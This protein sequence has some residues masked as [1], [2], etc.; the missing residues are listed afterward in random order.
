MV[1]W[2]ERLRKDLM[3]SLCRGIESHCG[4][5]M[6]VLR[7]KPYKPRFWVAAGVAHKR[8]LTAKNHSTKHSSKCAA[9]S[10]VMVTPA[11]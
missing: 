5:W 7:M 1:Q 8:F 10:P 9:L 4:T 2:L 3:I 6:P 11:R